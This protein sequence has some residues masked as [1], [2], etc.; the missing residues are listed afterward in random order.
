MLLIFFVVERWNTFLGNFFFMNRTQIFTAKKIPLEI[1]RI[2]HSFTY[3]Y[4]QRE[5]E[6][7]IQKNQSQTK[8][9]VQ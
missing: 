9:I 2:L 7:G 8:W 4:A 5:Y 3:F 6:I 1:G